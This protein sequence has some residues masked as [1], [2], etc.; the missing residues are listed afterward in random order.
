MRSGARP[1]RPFAPLRPLHQ[2][3]RVQVNK[4]QCREI[5]A[6]NAPRRTADVRMCTGLNGPWMRTAH[7]SRTR[8]ARTGTALRTGPFHVALRAAI[9][10]RRLPLTRAAPSHPAG[11]HRRG[12]QPELLAAGG[13]PPAAHRVAPRRARPEEILDLPEE[14]LIRLLA[15]PED[16]TACERPA[17]RSYRSLLEAYGVSISFLAELGRPPTA[18][19]TRSA[20]TSGCGSGGAASSSAATP[21]TSSRRPG[22][23]GPH[24]ATTTGTPAAYRTRRR[25]R[26]GELP[27]GA[28]APALRDRRARGELLFD[29]RPRQRHAPVPLRLRGRHGGPL[30]EY[31]RG[32]GFAGGQYALQ[33]RFDRGR[34]CPYAATASPSTRPRRRAAAAR[35]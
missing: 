5:G 17:A 34:H 15:K 4:V 18:G 3:L 25:P 30:T 14:S 27:H 16:H 2:L 35:S 1:S 11:R 24:V 19:C 29:A 31:A 8:R 9:A 22:R 28:R 20:T 32:S 23:R 33:G 7:S 12:D 6:V 26:P 13:E 10:A 21:S